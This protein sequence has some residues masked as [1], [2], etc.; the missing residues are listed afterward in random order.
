ML[1]SALKSELDDV[2]EKHQGELETKESLF[3]ERQKR[4]QEMEEESSQKPHMLKKIEN[5]ETQLAS[6][7]KELDVALQ[8]EN[9]FKTEIEQLQQRIADTEAR[10]SKVEYS[11]KPIDCLE[12]SR[13]VIARGAS[14]SKRIAS[15]L[16]GYT[17]NITR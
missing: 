14:E 7:R 9:A 1:I 2:R 15:C 11:W 16:F 10:V 5:L 13:S 12:R 8:N 3:L 4:N 17:G 6:K